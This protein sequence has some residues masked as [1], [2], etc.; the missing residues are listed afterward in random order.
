[1]QAQKIVTYTD[2]NGRLADI[3]IFKPSQRVELILLYSGESHPS[4]LKKRHPPRKLK[5]AVKEIGDI[6]SSAPV[7]DWGIS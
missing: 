7:S 4:T 5:G 3:P 2:N 6:F 1:M